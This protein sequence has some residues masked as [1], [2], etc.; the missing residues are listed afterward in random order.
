MAVSADIFAGQGPVIRL[1]G[2]TTAWSVR[3]PSRSAVELR[4]G[5]EGPPSPART[6]PDLWGGPISDDRYLV[7]ATA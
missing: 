7:L 1:I 6:A 5:E 2:A 3:P 4:A